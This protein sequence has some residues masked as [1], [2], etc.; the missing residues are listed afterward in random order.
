MQ[1]DFEIEDSKLS[2]K[3]SRD[4]ITVEILIYRGKDDSGWTLEVVD[5]EGGSTVWD[6]LFSTEGEALAEALNTI[7]TE[8]IACF[9]RDPPT[10]LH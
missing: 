2:Q 3:V 8:G 7:E 10:R 5:Q 6:D 4:G 9:L 1:E